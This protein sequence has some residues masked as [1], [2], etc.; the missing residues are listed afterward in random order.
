M[1]SSDDD[2]AIVD[3]A[4]VDAAPVPWW[5]TAW[6]LRLPVTIS[7]ATGSDLPAGFQIG[8]PFDLDHP[9]CSSSVGNYGDVRVVAGSAELARVIDAVG[10]PEWTWFRLTAPIAAGDTSSGEYWLYCDNPSAT[11]VADAGATVFDFYDP[12]DALSTATWNVHGSA[13]VTNGQLVCPG[14]GN[15]NGTVTNSAYAASQHAVDFAATLANGSAD[16]WGGFQ[17]GTADVRPWSLWYAVAVTSTAPSYVDTG[18]NSAILAGSF[19]PTDTNEHIYGV[20]D[21][22]GSAV[23]RF[24]DAIY[25]S[26]TYAPELAPP[27]SFALRLWNNTNHGG[28]DIRFDWIRL[29]QAA[30][31]PPDVVVGSAQMAP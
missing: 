27:S 8:V 4:I 20:E 1:A 11:D 29:R 31:P 17:T 16:W 30:S 28:Q 18:S 25:G 12:F 23:Y 9:P 21:Y 5:N 10:P 24:D 22:A 6:S 15:D 2:A 3:T 13:T 26:L 14:G 7:N 19:V